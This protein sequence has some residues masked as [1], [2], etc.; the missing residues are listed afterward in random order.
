MNKIIPKNRLEDIALIQ[1]G[2]GFPI[3][4]QGSL[5][6]KYPFYKVSDMNSIGNEMFMENAVNYVTEEV[7]KELSAKIIP[8]SS[9]I[10]PKVGGA[11]L[12]NKKRLTTLP[13]CIDNNVMS[14]WLDPQKCLTKYFLYFFNTIDLFNLSNKAALPS[15]T[16]ATLNELAVPLPPLPEQQL[17]AA[18][19]DETFAAIDKAKVNAEQN[20]KNARELFESYLQGVFEKKGDGW[21]YV[22]LKDEIELLT[23]FAFKSKDYSEDPED[24][25]LL[26]GDNIMQGNLRWVDVK[27]WR[28]SEY[29]YY[30]KY[31]L[32]EHDILLAMDRPW[33]KA[34]LKCAR[35]SKYDLPALLLQRT[36]CLRNKSKI[37]NSFLFYLVKSKGFM[38]HLLEAQT[39]IGVPHI[40]GTQI[41]EYSFYKPSLKTQQ[42]IVQKLDAL[43]A[44]TKKLE[45]IYQQK[46]KDLEELKKSILQKAFN[47]ELKA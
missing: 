15:I 12:T 5:N 39:G 42:T 34:G 6:G 19:L 30:K 35:L 46:L 25:P 18:I 32:K 31:H 37:E 41:M 47:G 24:V 8:S 7:R 4:Y 38:N 23:G 43:S 44:E 21:S 20:L 22:S 14:I 1:S 26:R 40:S 27:R 16:Q 45:T 28:K 17:I 29:D 13:S 2:T 36:A 10:F 9:I 3:K 33:V 11:I